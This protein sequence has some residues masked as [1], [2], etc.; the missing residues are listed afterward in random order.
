[1][2]IIAWNLNHRAARRTIPTWISDAIAEQ[3][4]DAVVLTEYVLGPDHV[5]F[6]ERLAA[7]GLAYHALTPRVGHS[8]QVLIAAGEPLDDG[9]LRAPALHTDVPPNF[10]HVRL[11][12][13]DVEVIGFRMP[14]FD[15]A[16]RPRKRE[17][18]EWLLEVLA[19]VRPR[20]AV[21]V[22]DFNTAPGDS[23]GDCG[24]CLERLVA[25]GWHHARPDAGYS[26][27]PANGGA[28]RQ[29]D[30][31][32]HTESL[33]AMRVNYSWDFQAYGEDAASGKVGRP[34]HAMLT[35]KVVAA[36]GPLLGTS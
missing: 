34:D 9:D 19:S 33:R 27:R 1:M 22:G 8:N 2:K 35:V 30:H 21:I 28:G 4:P 26:W 31:A 13:S 18:W 14:A 36:A 32:F 29:I 7:A 12:A 10:L 3:R 15:G 17:T 16:D 23:V 5:S 25:A 20:P 6:L 24:D 11:R